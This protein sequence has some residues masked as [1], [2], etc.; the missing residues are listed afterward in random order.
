[1]HILLLSKMKKSVLPVSLHPKNKR[2]RET[3]EFIFLVS[4]VIL[5]LDDNNHADKGFSI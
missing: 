2:E 5:F 4:D 1:M 3:W